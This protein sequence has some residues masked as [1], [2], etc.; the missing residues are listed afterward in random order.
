VQ[1]L[2][3]LNFESNKYLLFGHTLMLRLF[4]LSTRQR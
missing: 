3:L 1:P 2:C 4:F